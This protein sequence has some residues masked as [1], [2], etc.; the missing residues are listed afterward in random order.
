MKR[1]VWTQALRTAYCGESWAVP[2]HFLQHGNVDSKNDDM[3]YFPNSQ[4]KDVSNF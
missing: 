3:S 2:L 4:A 1:G